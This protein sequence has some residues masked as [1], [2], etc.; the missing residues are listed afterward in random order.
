MR[1]EKGIAAKGRKS[2]LVC[3]A[4]GVGVVG[5]MAAPSPKNGP[6]SLTVKRLKQAFLHHRRGSALP[7]QSG[8]SAAQ[9]QIAPFLGNTTA[10]SAPS[11]A[12][13]VLL[14]REPN[15]SLTYGAFSY[16][17]TATS[18]T[19]SQIQQTPNYEQTIHA[20]ALL[21]TTPDKFPNGCVDPK[22]GGTSRVVVYPGKTTTGQY[23]VAIAGSTFSISPTGT[24]TTPVELMTLDP[25]YSVMSADLNNDGNPDIVTINTSGLESSINVFLGKA[26]GTYTAGTSMTLPGAVAEFGVIDDLNGDGIPDLLV[27]SSTNGFQFSVYLGNGD[28]TFQ[29]GQAFVPTNT[30]LTPATLFITADVNGDGAKDIVTSQGQVFLGKGDGVTYTQVSQSGL[31]AVVTATNDYAPGMVTADFNNDGKLDLATDDG[32]TIRIYLG[33]GNGTFAAGTSY[34]TIPNRGYVMATDVDGDGNVDLVSGFVG[35]GIYG[36]DDYLPNLVYALIGNGDGTFQGAPVL[37][38]SY[39]GYNIA[40]LNGDGYPDMVGS[41][42]NS[43]ITL[44][45]QSSGVFK[46]GPPLAMPSGAAVDSYV[47]GDVNGDKIPDLVILSNAAQ[48]LGFYVALGNGD[49][50]FQT[51]TFIAAPSLVPSGNV[52]INEQLTGLRIAD[53]N[54]DGKL[55]LIYSYFDQTSQSQLYLEGFAVQLGNGNGTFAAPVI[56]TTYSSLTAPTYAFQNV[57]NAVIDVNGDNFPDVFITQPGAIVQGTAQSQVELFLG[58]GNGGFQTPSVP[59]LTPNL[60][61]LATQSTLAFGDLNGDGNVDIVASGSS[62]DG[63]TPELAIALGKG[64]GTFQ[65]PTILT[66]EGFGYGPSPAIAKFT[67]SGKLDV[68]AGGIFPGN[69]DGTLQT[70]TN[71]DGT[72]SAPQ[73]IVLAVQGGATGVDLNNDGKPD[74]VVGST[75]MINKTGEIQPPPPPNLAATTTNLGSSASTVTQGQSVT[76]TATVAGPSGNTT[77]PTGTVTF[78]D[79]GTAIGTGNVGAGGVATYS[80]TMLTTGTHTITAQ[81][82]GDGNFSTSTSSAIQVTVSSSSPDFSL[83]FSPASGTVSAGA[84]STTMLTV[85]PTGGFKAQTSLS[86][87]GAPQYATCSLSPSSVTPNGTAATS[88]LTITTTGAN[89]EIPFSAPGGRMRWQMG[90]VVA[91][92]ALV[93]CALLSRRTRM[94]WMVSVPAMGLLLALT[95]CAAGCNGGG[96]GGKSGGNVTPSGTYSIVVTATAGSTSHTAKYQLIVQ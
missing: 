42:G 23:L 71:S 68:Y 40:D 56:T 72:V 50:S 6:I 69:G 80:T 21:T 35:N 59:T 28:G 77:A 64:D 17:Y 39:T 88:T 8:N 16:V 61:M 2:M 96:G 54:H 82:N 32:T 19:G 94:S 84:I 3:V 65:S 11:T 57:L 46:A 14:A 86:C 87:S 29:A 67:G 93:V 22:W 58:N 27:S 24:P 53:F 36:G 76:F 47:I 81:Y 41:N 9:P 45:G 30:T 4:I 20:D 48:S 15:C 1:T 43:I 34:S 26:D 60:A 85:M 55:D 83:S 74:L 91:L 70:I 5:L 92:L 95:L 12:D 31:P 25:P 73:N 7:S 38:I 63:T 62:S 13:G 37:P 51:P 49:G 66:L 18:V 33:N 90:G 52:D 89:S 75:V 78:L 44:L 10:I 79:S